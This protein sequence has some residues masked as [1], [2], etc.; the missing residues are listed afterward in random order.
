MAPRVNA[1]P[2]LPAWNTRDI[3]QLDGN[4]LQWSTVIEEHGRKK[5]VRKDKKCAF[6]GKTYAGGP[7]EIEMHLDPLLVGVRTCQPKQEW[8]ERYAEVLKEL[9]ARRA[10]RDKRKDFEANKLEANNEAKRAAAAQALPPGQQQIALSHKVTPEDVSMQWM[11]AIAAKGL[12][13]DFVDHREVFNV[14]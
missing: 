2:D 1:P 11:R 7:K 10:V 5:T 12:P 14:T 9:R 13:L 6:C 4:A 3:D 8:S